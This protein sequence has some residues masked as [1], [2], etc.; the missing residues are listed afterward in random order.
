VPFELEFVNGE[1]LTVELV[2]SG[3]EPTSL[4]HVLTRIE[5]LSK[6]A[7]GWDS[8]GAQPLD[9]RAVRRAFELFSLLLNENTPEPSVIP[10]RDGG[11]QFEWHRGGTDLEVTCDPMGAVTY[12]LADQTTGEEHEGG[13]GAV[14]QVV[15]D[16]LLRFAQPA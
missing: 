9:P 4:W 8:Y 13:N 6:L 3:E 7:S 10:T 11:L 15:Q 12:Y 5:H 14:R 1:C 16:V 2:G